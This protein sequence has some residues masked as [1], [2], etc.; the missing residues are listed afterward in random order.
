MSATGRI[1]AP[2]LRNA[3]T[4]S[5][6]DISGGNISNSLTTRSSNFNGSNGSVSV[7]TYSFTSDPSTGLHL[8]SGGSY[9]AFDTSGVQRMCISGNLVG[10]GTTS[11]ANTLDI[12]TADTLRRSHSSSGCRI[13]AEQYTSDVK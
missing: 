6:Y 9:L 1:L 3:L 5:T 2:I 8:A 11:P 7:P 4:P 13:N 10:I 12:S